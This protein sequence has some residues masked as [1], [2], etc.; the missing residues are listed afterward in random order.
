MITLMMIHHIF[1]TL[2][3]PSHTVATELRFS[4][5]T[6]EKETSAIGSSVWAISHFGCKISICQRLLIDYIF[7]TINRRKSIPG[8]NKIG[9][10]GARSRLVDLD[11]SRDGVV[12]LPYVRVYRALGHKRRLGSCSTSDKSGMLDEH[13]IA[14]QCGSTYEKKQ[15]PNDGF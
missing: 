5:S 15:Q 8:L 7:V 4:H 6:V 13:E 11:P 2:M 3:P 1:L 12:F 14:F 10:T 9:F